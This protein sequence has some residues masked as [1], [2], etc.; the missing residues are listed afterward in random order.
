MAPRPIAS[1]PD[2]KGTMKDRKISEDELQAA[3]RKFVAAGGLIRKL[4]DQKIPPSQMVGRRW[5]NTAMGDEP[6]RG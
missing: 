1:A 3:M 2:R 6:N 4:P 5:N